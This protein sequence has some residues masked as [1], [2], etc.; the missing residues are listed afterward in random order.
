MFTPY[1]NINYQTG[2]NREEIAKQRPQFDMIPELDDMVCSNFPE[3]ILIFP[4]I[5]R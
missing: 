5:V 4:L 2:G 1:L 3:K